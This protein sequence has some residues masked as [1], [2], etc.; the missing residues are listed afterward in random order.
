VQGLVI[1]RGDVPPGLPLNP[2]QWFYFFSLAIA[3]GLFWLGANLIRSRVGRALV[4]IRDHP[5]AAAS[6][7]VDIARYKAITFGI[8]AMYT[9]I[10]GALSALLAQFVSPDSFSFFLSISLLVGA[11][12]G[13]VASIWGAVFGAFFIV[14]VPN[15]ADQITKAAPWA[16]YGLVLL[17]FMYL[18]PQGLA[19]LLRLAGER[20]KSRAR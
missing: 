12:V 1:D 16:I 2:D 20:L 17:G 7:G 4:A 14:Y 3:V 6:M 10:A 11:V 19:G 9:G 8:S 18:M 13:G 5:I 15:W